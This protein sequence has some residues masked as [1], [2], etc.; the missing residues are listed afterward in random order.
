MITSAKNSLVNLIVILAIPLALSGCHKKV[1]SISC[2]SD[3]DCRVDASGKE[4]NGVCHEGKCEECVEDTDCQGL[5]QC[6]NNRC[7]S[8]CQVD[9]DC[10]SDK[11][12][13]NSFCTANCNNN[14]ACGGNGI[15]AQG[16]C[17]SQLD[18]NQDAVALTGDQCNA[19]ASIHFDFDRF[20]IKPEDRVHVEQ[21]ASC[22]ENN[23]GYTV[24]IEGHTD[25]RGTPVYNMALG[26]K[27]ANAVMSYLK[28][29]KGIA[30][31]R[32][33]TVSYG[34]QKPV[35]DEKSEYAW[36]QNRR[37]QFSFNN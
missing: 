15:C 7:E 6:I 26:E 21:L 18:V 11:H 25:D 37:A 10:G 24:T 20:D 36:G 17:V 16:R 32:I 3:S 29:D 13:E 2:K 22:L 23:P 34:E 33:K 9:A 30:S 27:R 1:G 4:I 31:N 12:C 8:S 28:N 35:L 5:K 19:L 14:E